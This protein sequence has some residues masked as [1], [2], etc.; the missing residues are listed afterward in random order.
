MIDVETII[1]DLKKSQLVVGIENNI[2]K[3]L[4]NLIEDI[5][6]IC[7]IPAPSFHEQN[8]AKFL[9]TKLTKLGLITIIDS[10]TNVIARYPGKKSG[11]KLAICAHIDTVF[12]DRSITVKK[13]RDKLSAPGI[14]DNSTSVAGMIFIIQSWLKWKYTPPFDILFVGNSCEEGLGDLRGIRGFL[15]NYAKEPLKAMIALDGTLGFVIHGGI[16]SRRLKV[17]IKSQGGHSWGDFGKLSAIHILG[18]CIADISNLKVPKNPR[19]T[20]NVGMIEGGTSVNTIAEYSSMLI[21]IR[22]MKVG[23]LRKLENE[24]RS[25]INK[26]CD[27]SQIQSEIQVVGDRPSGNIPETH[28]LVQLVKASAN[29]YHI[30]PTLGV[31][32]TDA[33]IPLSRN[34][35]ALAFGCYT[36]ADAH[37]SSECIFPSSLEKGI[38]FSNLAFLSVIQWIDQNQ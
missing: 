35:P 18:Q 4:P 34:I 3:D 20:Y 14:G 5:I 9:H 31:S 16:G 27:G 36:G 7:E 2:T 21:D 6:S 24:I 8:R 11:A 22:S 38:P 23:N 17:T 33:N 32:S 29:H 1:S 12:S 25:I 15:D 13:S 26:R 30:N 37:R 19:T 10:Y 28:P